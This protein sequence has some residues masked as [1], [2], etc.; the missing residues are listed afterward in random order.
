MPWPEGRIQ[1]SDRDPLRTNPATQSAAVATFPGAT[2][3][4]RLHYIHQGHRKQ[5]LYKKVCLEPP[6]LLSII[7]SLPR[8]RATFSKQHKQWGGNLIKGCKAARC[9][10]DGAMWMSKTSECLLDN[11]KDNGRV[12][13]KHLRTSWKVGNCI[14]MTVQTKLC[15][16]FPSCS[17]LIKLKACFLCT[18]MLLLKGKQKKISH[19]HKD[20]RCNRC[21]FASFSFQH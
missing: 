17:Y 18:Q 5:T 21:G 15:V 19:S 6:L 14:L 2:S 8:E 4:K 16:S 11:K 20:V 12:Q 1:A 10:G 7:V 13:S 9:M 3:L